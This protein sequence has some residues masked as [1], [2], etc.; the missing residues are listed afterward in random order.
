MLNMSTVHQV[1]MDCLLWLNSKSYELVLGH[2]M[3]KLYC[4]TQNQLDTGN[5][6]MGPVSV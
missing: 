3:L 5:L 2:M 1:T 6:L 4:Q